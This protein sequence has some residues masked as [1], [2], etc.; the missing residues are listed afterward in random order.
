MQRQLAVYRKKS[1]KQAGRGASSAFFMWDAVP[2]PAKGAFLEKRSVEPPKTSSG[3][4]GKAGLSVGVSCT[5]SRLK[6]QSLFRS[7][8]VGGRHPHPRGFRPPTMHE[9]TKHPQRGR[10]LVS[11]DWFPKIYGSGVPDSLPFHK[12]YVAR[13]QIKFSDRPLFQKGAPGCRAGPCKERWAQA[14]PCEENRVAG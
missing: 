3:R 1:V 14:E 7:C 6:R 5:S 2:H 13:P 12:K 10:R 11:I 8:M 9:S 4:K